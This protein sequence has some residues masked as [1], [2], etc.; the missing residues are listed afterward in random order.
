M[1]RR[2]PQVRRTHR[3][4]RYTFVVLLILSSSTLSLTSL[5]RPT[6]EKLTSYA[7]GIR[8]S[9]P[10]TLRVRLQRAA[11][12]VQLVSENDLRLTPLSGSH[13]RGRTL[14][15]PVLIRIEHD[16][17]VAS[18]ARGRTRT[19][20]TN[21]PLLISSKSE[22]TFNSVA[23]PG[24]IALVRNPDK[25][26]FD[27]IE[28]VSIERYLPGVLTREL[29]PNWSQTTYEAQAI[30]ARSYALN[31]RL[32]RLSLGSSFD[33]ENTTKDQ[34]Y[35]GSNASDKA[36][37]AVQRTQ[38][39]T[40]I[41][42]GAILRAYYSS[43]CGGRPASA[44]DTWPT[45]IG[46]EYNLSAPLQAVPRDCPDSFSPR[47]RWTVTRTTQTLVQRLQAFGRDNGSSLR[48]ITSLK[49]IKPIRR[50]AAQRPATYRLTDQAGK[51]W[52]LSAEQL[53]LALNHN[54][55]SRLGRPDKDSSVFSGDVQIDI[56]GDAVTILGRGFG[57]G[58]GMCQFGAEGLARQGKSVEEILTFYYPGAD[59]VRLY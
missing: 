36:R 57:H 42:Q 3:I 37:L 58:V 17:Y 16:H 47:F 12:Q 13:R 21:V 27:V 35:G 1:E 5:G 34:A 51:S 44:R 9:G 50:N 10:V 53:R 4:E 22:L 28:H 14:R 7:A 59:V 24:A 15:S 40:L 46:F 6:V 31:E 39:T 49:S 55:S 23:Y 11:K 45:G 29:Y 30:A 18:G 32:R 43:V 2:T 56:D 33:L 20:S 25:N 38:G 19:F 48:L 52:R 54:G 41:Y 8:A 26:T